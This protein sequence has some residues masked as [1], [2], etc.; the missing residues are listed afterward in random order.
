MEAHAVAS[1]LAE[2][3]ADAAAA[4]EAVVAHLRAAL[5]IRH[6]AVIGPR[7]GELQLGVIERVHPQRAGRQL[8]GR[9]LRR[10][11]GV[12]PH[13]WVVD[14]R[15][16]V[17]HHVLVDLGM[18]HQLRPHQTRA[19]R[20]RGERH[21]A[22]HAVLPLQLVAIGIERH[23]GRRFPR[24]KAAL[25]VDVGHH[26]L[27]A[28]MA[29][30]HAQVKAHSALQVGDVGYAAV[31]LGVVA[32]ERQAQIVRVRERGQVAHRVGLRAAS[33]QRPPIRVEQVGG[34]ARG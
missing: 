21:V 29:G 11:R 7:R 19:V 33:G 2:T 13:V 12:G 9:P 31:G 15:H 10:L 26:D 32:P 5:T 20:E 17:Q 27:A 16:E 8:H 28:V 24:V 3:G 34:A 25:P 14:R 18:V 1:A 23:V 22:I 4:D 6:E 30:E